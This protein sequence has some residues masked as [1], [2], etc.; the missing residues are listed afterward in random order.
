MAIS[1]AELCQQEIAP[2]R[3]GLGG[4]CFGRVI[5]P[6]YGSGAGSGWSGADR[7]LH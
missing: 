6:S 2:A 5:A 4:L 1:T 3:E 7:G